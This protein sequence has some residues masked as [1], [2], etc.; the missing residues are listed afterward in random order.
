MATKR[1]KRVSDSLPC[2]LT[3]EERLEFA[4]ALAEASQAVENADSAKKAAM[5]QHNYEIQLAQARRDKLAGIVASKTEYREVTVEETIDW[6]RDKYTRVRTDTGEVIMDRRLNDKEKQIQLLEDG[7]QF[8]NDE[9]S[10]T[11]NE[12]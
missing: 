4:D 8:T 7:E 12:D 10:E 6:N 5:K 1:V 9:T 3:D 11:P 2:K